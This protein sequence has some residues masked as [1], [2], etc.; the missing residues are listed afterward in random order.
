MKTCA[1]CKQTLPLDAF[2]L[3]RR[4]AGGRQSYCIPCRATYHKEW[5][6]RNVEKQRANGREAYR[7]NPNAQR[8]AT[9]R[10]KFGITVDDYDRLLEGQGGV[11]ALCHRPEI[12]LHQNGRVRRLAVDHDHV[13]GKVRGLLCYACNVRVG[14]FEKRNIDLARYL[15]RD[16]LEIEARSA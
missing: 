15:E 10:A 1:R 9:L 13:T 14:Y 7:R 12:A 2:H 5:Y 3:H 6:Y 4:E 11:C 16:P 8:N